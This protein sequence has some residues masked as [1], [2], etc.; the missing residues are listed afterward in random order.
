M[1]SSHGCLILLIAVGLAVVGI[2]HPAIALASFAIILLLTAVAGI[3]RWREAPPYTVA[4]R[5]GRCNYPLFGVTKPQ[6]P[7]CGHPISE[8]QIKNA[9]PGIYKFK[10]DSDKAHG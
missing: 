5:C 9:P 1:R 6:C 7:E 10:N 8:H 3:I 4:W 2:A